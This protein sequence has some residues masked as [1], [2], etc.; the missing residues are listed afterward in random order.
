MSNS[1]RYEGLEVGA[2]SI[3]WVRRSED[4]KIQYEVASHGGEPRKLIEEI[5][6]RNHI[7]DNSRLVITGQAARLILD[8]PYRPETECLERAVKEKGLDPDILLSLGGE[9]CSVYPMKD[10][11]IRNVISTSKCAAG[12]GEFIVQQFQRMGL[13]LEDGLK[14]AEAGELVR[15]ATRCSVHLKSDATHKLNKGECGPGD[16]ARSLIHDLALKVGNMIESADW[17]VGRIIVCGGVAGNSLFAAFLREY[18]TD[19]EILVLPESP[20]LEAFGASLFASEQSADLFSK[21]AA[22]YFLPTVREFERLR[23]LTEAEPLLDFRVKQSGLEEIKPDGEYI[24]G[25]DAGS[26]TTKA[27]LLNATDGSVGA[28]CYLRTLGNPIHAAKNC[29]AELIEKVGHTSIRVLS[30]AATGSAREMVSVF[31]DNCSSFNEIL[32]HA[33][34]AGSES[35]NVDTVF[36]IGGQ[37][38]K[39]ISFQDGIPVDYAMNEGCSAGT[40]SFLE[41]SASVDMGLSVDEIGPLAERSTKPIAF[42]ER[43]AAFIN[44]DVRNS[45]QQGGNREDVVAGLVYSIADNYISRVVGPRHVGEN[46]MF[47]GGVALNRAVALAMAARTG[48]RV[49][50]PPHPELMGGV[51]CALLARDALEQGQAEPRDID[52]HELAQGEMEVKGSFICRVCENVCPIQNITVKGKTYP[53]GGPCSRYDNV[54]HHQDE[55]HEGRDLIAFRNQLMFEEYGPAEL[56]NPRGVIGLPLVLTTFELFPFYASLINELGYNAALSAPSMMSSFKT[57]A[58]VCY[59]CELVHGAINDLIQR[60][61]DFIFLPHVI[62]LGISTGGRHGY[63]CPSTALIPDLI[64]AGFDGA[65]DKVLSPHIGLSENLIET[66]LRELTGLADTLGVTPDQARTAGERAMD[67]YFEFLDRYRS[68]GGKELERIQGEPA[69]ILAGRP[70]TTCAREVNLALP[71]K[72]TSRGYHVIPADLFAIGDGKGTNRNVWHYTQQIAGALEKAKADPDL[73]ICLLSCFSCGPD[74]SMYHS[75]RQ[76]L[77]G[78]TFCYLEIDS[79]T[80]HAGFE[81]RVGAFL[82]IVERRRA[83]AQKRPEGKN[84]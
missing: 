22:D 60:E 83:T 65:S 5:F 39:F 51:G 72:I 37:D 76:E 3:K 8:A 59:P 50:V 62:E 20:Y 26:T 34:A 24:L 79:H 81:T 16:I 73:Y 7:S 30:V 15:L 75:F 23:P 56:E 66:T 49:V 47:L 45:L 10:G 69:V 54:R 4:G 1:V 46:L 53:F 58:P 40:G 84:E 13:S 67:R 63:V 6:A 71:R 43:C 70:Y 14:E 17:P 2:V 64:R 82:D 35:P 68:E 48:R 61:V 12:T 25:V 32:S 78:E 36:E 9:T 44:T 27:V 77:S 38:S 33:R 29:L 41:E 80:A 52:L 28:S 11:V 55:V 21:N 31:L 18:F 19:S 57:S 42:G 74:A